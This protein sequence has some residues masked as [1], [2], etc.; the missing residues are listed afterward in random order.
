MGVSS[1]SSAAASR[2]SGCSVSITP[3]QLVEDVGMPVVRDRVL[4]RLPE[5]PLAQ[6]PSARAI[7]THPLLFAGRATVHQVVAQERELHEPPWDL[8]HVGRPF[9]HP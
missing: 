9:G 5:I 1:A 8:S 3:Q 7:V 6:D 2:A 4:D